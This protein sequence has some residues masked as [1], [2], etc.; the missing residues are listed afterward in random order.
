[1]RAIRASVPYAQTIHVAC[2]LL[3]QEAADLLDLG[4]SR[5][6][7]EEQVAQL[8][9]IRLDVDG[10]LGRP[11]IAFQ[12]QDLMLRSAPLLNRVHGARWDPRQP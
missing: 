1:M 5:L 2:R 3:F 10:A 9:R 6:G 7:V 12:D 11:R 4:P 8:A